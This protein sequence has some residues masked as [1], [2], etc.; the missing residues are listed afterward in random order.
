MAYEETDIEKK[1]RA[2]DSRL[3]KILA[4]DDRKLFQDNNDGYNN[5]VGGD[6]Q[7]IIFTNNYAV[8]VI[9]PLYVL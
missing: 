4:N 5:K 7:D 9:L 3:F 2:E 8:G 1:K 6:L